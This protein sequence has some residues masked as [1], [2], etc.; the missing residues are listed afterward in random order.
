MIVSAMP[1]PTA[2]T[3][4]ITFYKLITLGDEDG[5]GKTESRILRTL[6]AAMA[7]RKK[8]G[9]KK[10]LNLMDIHSVRVM[11]IV[12]VTFYYDSGYVMG[13][14]DIDDA[15]PFVFFVLPQHVNLASKQSRSEQ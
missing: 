14:C 3:F 11:L 10:L 1:L 4:Y 13:M 7:A 5:C 6:E 9:F 12:G 2:L 15:I 8:K